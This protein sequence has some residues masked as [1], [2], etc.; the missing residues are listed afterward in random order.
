MSARPVFLPMSQNFIPIGRH[1]PVDRSKIED[2]VN[3]TMQTNKFFTNAFIGNQNQP[4][5]THPYAI[6]WGKGEGSIGTPIYPTWGMNIAHIEANEIEFEPGT[7]PSY[8]INPTRRAAVII[9]AKELGAETTLTVDTVLPFSANLNL[10]HKPGNSEPTI[11]F[12]VVQGMSFITGGYRNS[13]P[14]IQCGGQNGFRMVSQPISVGKSVKYRLVDSADRNW[15]VYI[16]PIP[17]IQ[18][19]AKQFKLT[20]HDFTGP[21]GFTGTIQVTK[22]P[23]R[24]EGE[25][26]YD[27]ASGTFVIHANLTGEV[28]GNTGTYSF[29]YTKVGESPLLMFTLPHHIG[30]LAPELQS[31]ITKLVLRTTTKG[32]ATAVWAN[33]DKLTFVENN[34]PITMGFGPW[35]PQTGASKMRFT[36]QTLDI[37]GPIAEKDL[38]FVMEAQDPQDS[39]YYSG[40]MFARFATLLYVIK[41]VLNNGQLLATG[42]DKLKKEMARYIENRQKYPIFYDDTWKGAVSNSGYNN[43][44]A[45]FGNTY[46]ND[47]HFHF[48]YFVYTASMIAYM[49]PE[50]LKQGSNKAWVQMLVK[51]FAESDENG[52][53]YPFCRSFDWWHGH[54]WAKGLFESADGKDE[55]STSEDGFSS[56][57]LKM[58]GKVIGDV[59]MEKRGNLMLAIQ[60]R[61]FN[62]YY[63]MASDNKIQP[64]NFIPN[65]V[66]II[67]ENKMDHAT[68]FGREPQFTQ[69]I[70]M[71]PVSPPSVFLRPKHF[72]RE[73]WDIFFSN[74]RADV[75]NHGWRSILYANLAII[76]PKASWNFFANGTNGVWKD[77]WIDGGS[78]RTWYLVWAAALGGGSAR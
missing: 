54:S 32:N 65:K 28:N 1:H 33:N 17:E 6:W 9:S 15:V 39:M 35:N 29:S 70:H 36:Q 23:I 74:G 68:Y 75:D 25:K 12:P 3:K 77:D 37:I 19:D 22:N 42:L 59:N 66:G 48:G 14:I 10:S 8:Y 45:D 49:D 7:P 72:V 40:K 34:L 4:I 51:D 64:E 43:P 2:D 21:S 5:W 16:N 47:H 61:S 38:K 11:T 13:T 18:Y 63:Y 30:S 50:W 46:Y 26:L 41:D 56:F 20:D 76:D 55:E 27:K 57:A 71:V 62:S 52:R 69:G 31:N 60:A 78:T 24:D 53:D 67:F 73:E 58:W 44:G